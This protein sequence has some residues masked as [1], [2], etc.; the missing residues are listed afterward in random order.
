MVIITDFHL[1]FSSENPQITLKSKT[2][3][4]NDDDNKT[5]V[6]HSSFVCHLRFLLLGLSL[7][8]VHVIL[9]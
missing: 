3:N 9:L 7:H 2:N 1:T 6:V 8:N 5:I 4:C